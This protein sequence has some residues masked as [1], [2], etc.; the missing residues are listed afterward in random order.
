MI[1]KCFEL[2][3]GNIGFGHLTDKLIII[4]V[5]L[6]YSFLTE[7]LDVRTNAGI[8]FMNLV[9]GLH[10]KKIACC[11]LNWFTTSSNDKKLRRLLNLPKQETVVA[12]L[13]CGDVPDKF[14]VACSLKNDANETLVLH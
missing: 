13:V 8:I 2:Q 10:Y 7:P 9:Y 4:T 5:D 11:I 3:G 14:K 12:F 6:R 1:K